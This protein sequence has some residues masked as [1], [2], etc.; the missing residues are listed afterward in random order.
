MAPPSAAQCTVPTRPAPVVALIGPSDVPDELVAALAA[1]GGVGIALPAAAGADADAL[2]RST[3]A[4]LACDAL[5]V[6]LPAPTGLDPGSAAV[7]QAVADAGLP[8]CVL[9]AG[10]GPETADFEDLTAIAARVLGAECVPARLPVLDDDEEVAGSLDLVSLAIST[11]AGEHAAEPEHV[12]LT[13]ELRDALVTEVA[14]ASVDDGFA[15]GVLAG[16]APSAERLRGELAAAV[17][18]GDCAP[19]LAA[20]PDAGWC[21]DLVGWLLAG[22]SAADPG[23]DGFASIAHPRLVLRDA[24][25]GA[26]AGDAGVVLAAGPEWLLA[27][28]VIGEL[29]TGMA[30][31][32]GACV[33]ADGTPSAERAWPT[34]V[35]DG[36]PEPG[37][38]VRFATP[39]RADIGDSLAAGHLWLLPAEQF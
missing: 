26:A 2:L 17:L 3:I 32:N 35:G 18:A 33:G 29:P 4:A 34:L 7:W 25:G 11:P 21:A 10:I 13:A 24:E 15:A 12:A 20:S 9:V 23:T 8:R 1:A 28:A 5:V 22:D 14:V 16:I 19:V 31:I 39:I 36:Q 38:L 27:R 30:S 37:G 6:V